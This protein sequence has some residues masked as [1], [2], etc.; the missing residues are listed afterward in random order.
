MPDGRPLHSLI[1]NLLVYPLIALWTLAG[2]LAFPFL[3]AFWKIFVNAD[4]SRIMRLFVWVYGRGWMAIMS[5]FVTFRRDGFDQITASAPYVI[6]VNHLS[7]FDFYCMAL[8]PFDNVAAAVRSWPFRMP[9]YG[10]FMRLAGYLDVE[11]LGWKGTLAKGA[12]TLS[13]GG[14]IVFFPEG[15]RSRDGKLHRF[16]S[17]PF[18]LSVET[19]V[20][21]LPLCLTGT[22]VLLPPGRWWISPA[23]ICLTALPPVDPKSFDGPSAHL[24]LR[25]FIQ[26]MMARKINSMRDE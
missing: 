15:H 4:R 26:A 14:S 2:I 9:W 21:V 8:L 5:P 25:K 6:V 3:Y 22:D 18:R 13:E 23:R 16:M 24:K 12:E 7:F 19:G 10:P 11:S 1:M 20:K 17:G